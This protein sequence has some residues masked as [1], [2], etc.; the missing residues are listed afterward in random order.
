MTKTITRDGLTLSLR[1]WAKHL[2]V[3]ETTL[4][5]RRYM[6]LSDEEV[7]A[8]VRPWGQP[9]GPARN[10]AKGAIRRAQ[11]AVVPWS[12]LEAITQFY[13]SCPCG[14][15]V[16]HVYPL[17]G[18]TVSGLHVLANLQYLTP[19]LNAIKAA[20]ILSADWAGQDDC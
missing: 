14:Q 3:K 5:Q 7:L 11:Q 4:Y 1:G 12:E 15:V 20:R 16:D 9:D 10:R 6:G 18:E 13:A 19:E 8:P 2:G 17:R